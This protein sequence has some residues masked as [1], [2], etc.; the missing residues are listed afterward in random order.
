MEKEKNVGSKL[1]DENLLYYILQNA[2]R[3]SKVF[4]EYTF[5]WIEIIIILISMGTFI[6]DIV[7]G[8]LLY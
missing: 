7:T 4:P 6:A 2:K 1:K 5:S 3:K 8:R